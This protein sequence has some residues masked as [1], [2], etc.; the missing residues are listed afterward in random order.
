[1]TETLPHLGFAL[2]VI[3]ALAWVVWMCWR[4]GRKDGNP[5]ADLDEGIRRTLE[6]DYRGRRE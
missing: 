5:F 3:G 6:D 4:D 1:M 2:L